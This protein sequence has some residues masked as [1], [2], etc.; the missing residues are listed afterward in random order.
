MLK[1]HAVI[2]KRIIT[3]KSFDYFFFF[4]FAKKIINNCKTNVQQRVQINKQD[5]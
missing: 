5:K 3:V 4:F 2:S 1:Q